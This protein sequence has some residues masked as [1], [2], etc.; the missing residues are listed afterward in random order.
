MPVGVSFTGKPRVARAC[1]QFTHPAQICPNSVTERHTHG[2]IFKSHAYWIGEFFLAALRKIDA[3][4]TVGAEL[5]RCPF[6]EL[7]AQA[8]AV[9]AAPV[10]HWKSEQFVE[11]AFLSVEGLFIEF[12]DAACEMN[13]VHGLNEPDNGEIVFAADVYAD[14]ERVLTIHEV[15]FP[16]FAALVF[17]SGDQIITQK[18]GVIVGRLA[19]EFLQETFFIG[20]AGSD[21]R[22]IIGFIHLD[23][24]IVDR[25]FALQF[26]KEPL[27]ECV[28][29]RDAME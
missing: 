7:P 16:L 1:D 17:A 12:N 28:L 29:Q 5:F 25:E 13:A 11:G 23:S 26:E 4:N 8:A 24:R 3:F 19:H 22:K 15:G 14:I 9:Y 10:H 20:A 27:V 2:A 21:E 6:S 18:R